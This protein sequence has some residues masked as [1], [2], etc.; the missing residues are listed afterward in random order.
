MSAERLKKNQTLKN[1]VS[2]SVSFDTPEIL[3]QKG[4]QG[5]H[6][7]HFFAVCFVFNKG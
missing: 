1:Q 3:E 7:N 6:T 4:F 5:V 2:L